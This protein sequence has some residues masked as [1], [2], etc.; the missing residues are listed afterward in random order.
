MANFFVMDA[1]H[2]HKKIGRGAY[3]ASPC[4]QKIQ[5]ESVPKMLLCDIVVIEEL[6]IPVNILGTV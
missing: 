6:L 5:A 3:R 2:H 4:T 1:S